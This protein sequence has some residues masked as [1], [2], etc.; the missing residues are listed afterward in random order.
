M[1]AII[2][3]EFQSVMFKI[4]D[5][6]Y[7]RLTQSILLEGCR[8]PLVTWNNILIDGYNRY[9]ICQKYNIEFSTVE[10]QIDFQGRDEVKRWIR[11]NQLGKR[12]LTQ[13]QRN[14]LIGLEYK[15]QKQTGF[16]GNQ[17][18]ETAPGHFDQKQTDEQ[19]AEEY[20]TSPKTVRRAEKFVDAVDIIAANVGDDARDEILS[21]EL[22]VTVKDVQVLA[23]QEPEAQREV[24]TKVRSGKSVKGAIAE[25]RNKTTPLTFDRKYPPIIHH[26]SYDV[27]LNRFDDA[28]VDLLLTDPP[29]MT[30][31]DNIQQF[32]HW[33]D[34]ALPKIKPTGRAYIC[35]GA[36][37]QELEA[38]LSIL[39]NQNE[40]TLA[41]ILVWTYR[42]TLGPKPKMT[43][44][45]N[46]QAVLYLYGKEAPPINCPLMTEQF[47]VQNI[48]AP[49]GR[50]GIRYDTWQK[51]DEL[52][53]RLVRHS[54]QSDDLVIDCFA[55]T[56]SF[57]L[58]ASKL[59]RQAEGC[60]IDESKIDIA[61]K[62]GC[63]DGI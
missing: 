30:D 34:L 40:F 27:F 17:Y 59:G 24:V 50:T 60:D 31:I 11:K 18:T 4:R 28:S 44:M 57:L 12:N 42:N 3:K 38:Y 2:D 43:Y 29:Y 51:P 36:Y 8:D 39:N 20:K 46:W 56:G 21:R 5:D 26:L 1:N 48:N 62:R 47:A 61:K 22:D 16:K 53:E 55:G 23:K 41:N 25:I 45:L 63:I 49:D 6:E 54:T 15:E 13:E 58:A 9:E 19:V 37:P 32:A 35:I 33:V 14:Y 10:T 52:G 7:E